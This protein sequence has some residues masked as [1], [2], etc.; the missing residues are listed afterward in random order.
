[1][2]VGGRWMSAV[3]KSRLKRT[4]FSSGKPKKAGI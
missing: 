3:R 2:D 4:A 1:L